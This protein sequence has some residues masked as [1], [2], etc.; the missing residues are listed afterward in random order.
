MR[1]AVYFLLIFGL[2]S[3]AAV[4][5]QTA[6][7]TH[8][9]ILLQTD[10][11][12]LDSH[13][14]VKGTVSCVPY[15]EGVHYRIN[16]SNSWF[17]NLSIP[18]GTQLTISFSALLFKYPESYSIRSRSIIQPEFIS[19]PDPFKLESTNKE[20]SFFEKREALQTNGSIMRGLTLGTG[21]NSVLNS[22]M[23]LQLAGRINNEVDV[24]AAISDDN[25]PIQ[26]EGNT[27]DLQDFDQVFVKFSKDKSE[28]IAGDFLMAKPAQS[29]FMNYY[30]KSRGLH[31][32]TTQNLSPKSK[33]HVLADAAISRGRFVRN[34]ING[35]EGN[36]GPYR[37]TGPNGEL[38]III[39]SGT[40]AVYLDGER[41][42]R[43][44]Q[45]DYT[46]DYN[47]GEITFMPKRLITSFSRIVV[48]FQ[49]SD[50]YYA[51]TVAAAQLAWELRNHRFALNVYSEQDNKNQPFQQSLSDSNK[52]FLAALGNRVNEAL[53]TGEGPA[54]AFESGKI[55]YRKTDSLGYPTVYV[56]APAKGDDSLY[57]ELRFSYLGTNKGNYIQSASAAN[58]R[59]FKW[60][61]PING[62]PQGDFEPV[63]RLIAPSKRQMVTLGYQV[64][65]KKRYLN[66]ELAGSNSDPN[67]FSSLDN[68]Q[69]LAGAFRL[70][71]GNTWQNFDS[72]IKVVQEAFA[73]I[74]G[75]NFQGI[76]R[77]R[78]VEF[79]RIWQRQLGNVTTNAG[80]GEQWAGL[81]TQLNWKRN[82]GSTYQL[83]YFNRG[84]GI[85]QGIQQTLETRL[86][87]KQHFLSFGAEWQQS[88]SLSKNAVS[89]YRAEW[90]RSSPKL[91]YGLRF[92][93]ES[94]LFGIQSDSLLSGSFAFQNLGFYLGNTDTL[95]HALR[96]QAD[97]RLD[98]RAS[99]K[100][101]AAYSEATELKASYRLL[102]RNF[103]RFSAD[104]AYREFGIN[105]LNQLER[106]F[107]G[108]IEYDYK[109]LNR[110]IQ[111]NTYL[112]TGSGNE[113]RRDFQ[114][115]EVPLA[116]GMYVW[117]DF[118][119]NGIQDL[120]EFV[121]AALADKNLANYIKVFLPSSSLIP[122]L[123]T[124]MNQTLSI[125]NFNFWNSKS[126]LGSWLGHFS[127]QAGFRFEQKKRSGEGSF[128][129]RLRPVSG[130]DTAL[131]SEQSS[132]RNTLFFNRN[133]PVFGMDYSWQQQNQNLLQT[134]GRELRFRNEHKLNLRLNFNSS[135]SFQG[136]V[137]TGTKSVFS[138]YFEANRFNYT[139]REMR[140]VL[141]YQY[142]QWLRINL[143]YSW[144]QAQ[145]RY[146]ENRESALTQELGSEL[147]LS[148]A[149]VGLLSAKFSMY[150]VAFDGEAA[151]NLAYDMLQ[152]L[153]VGNNRIWGLGLQQRLGSN[154]QISLNYDGRQSPGAPILHTGRMEAR[155]VF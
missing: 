77:Y 49:Y 130:N 108:R 131:I 91:R 121:P 125:Q 146:L 57:Y 106:T 102:Q 55:L 36:Q 124:S 27:V 115:V 116:Q 9:T 112:Q 3:F 99:G 7:N 155:Y 73:E 129:D 144:F 18:K 70:D 10:S 29:W 17:Y 58:G 133:H 93:Q 1:F 20:F 50:R 53:V 150:Q 97:R 151:G 56:Y 32:Q 118:N 147:R 41:L 148:W 8:K 30:K 154:L 62:I 65:Q 145:N 81:K 143:N 12:L 119:K 11:F 98:Q 38:F 152:G 24:L 35:M 92:Q 26:P 16:Y 31:M 40:E 47:S 66:L 80:L 126:V 71:M 109:L 51:R 90:G 19:N 127:N 105:H 25:N 43:G 137:S 153:S 104:L 48:E 13:S 45:N 6:P 37:L 113:L 82:W 15:V 33:L 23:N 107:L 39:I 87:L 78:G 95:K 96:L 4:N 135:W 136:A 114:Y 61:E 120:N 60:V 28:L 67:T 128:L 101:M 72:S 88:E 79:D 123:S 103:N 74:T 134:N 34:Q 22:N 132:W 63:Q 110:K 89:N 64:Q 111:A 142:L 117:K 69:N 14:I 21:G 86:N 76:E 100:E 149:K 46:I 122:T 139:F 138:D 42:S 5:A 59:V 94:S 44:E 85:L 54:K 84:N 75:T 141:A 140:P 83:N 68:R 2:I 52:L